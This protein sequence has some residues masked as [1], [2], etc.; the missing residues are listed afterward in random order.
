MP[1]ILDHVS[2]LIRAPK[3]W[4]ALLLCGFATSLSAQDLSVVGNSRR[5]LARRGLRFT[6]HLLP[7]G[8]VI[9]WPG[10]NFGDN[11]QICRIPLLIVHQHSLCGLQPVLR[12]A[13]IPFRW[14]AAG[15]GWQSFDQLRTNEQHGIRFNFRHMGLPAGYEFSALVPYQH[16]P[17]YR[18]HVGDIGR[19]RSHDGECQ[20]PGN[21]PLLPAQSEGSTVACKLFSK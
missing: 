13:R 20:Y 10:Y 1:T 5:C 18:R 2:S 9:F 6:L 17:L 11:A 8:K 19:D 3:I 21:M 15:Y 16:C 12:R 14:A 7:T 4:F